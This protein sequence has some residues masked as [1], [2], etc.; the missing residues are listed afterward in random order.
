M[1]DNKRVFFLEKKSV[2]LINFILIIFVIMSFI[3]DISLKYFFY[4]NVIFTFFASYFFFK[5][6]RK[7][8]KMLIV[9]N[10]FIFFYFLYPNVSSF[11]S[12]IFG[13]EGYIFII[14][15][16]IVIAYLFLFFSG[17]TEGFAKNLRNTNFLILAIVALIGLS[18]GLFF[19]LIR[20]PIPTIFTSF[21]DNNTFEIVKFLL[22]SSFLVAFSEQ[23]IFSG[24]LFNVYRNLTSKHDAFYQTAIIFVMF[25]LL[26]FEVLVKHYFINFNEMYIF[27]IIAYYFLLFSFM[28]TALYLYSFKTEKYEGNFFYP[29][30][31]HFSADFG[32]FIFYFIGI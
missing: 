30:V 7:L 19:T 10:M 28:L 1:Q 23:M 26:R 5:H 18:F 17:Y 3:F 21:G 16:N 14:F 6:S 2:F 29:V 22:F 27:Y 4:F 20:E 24:F 11:L 12:E 32:L 25:H 31:L 15:Y 9:T 13:A 8:A